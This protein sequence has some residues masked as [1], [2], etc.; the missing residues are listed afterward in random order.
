MPPRVTPTAPPID[1]TPPPAAVEPPLVA[2]APP[3]TQPPVTQ[4]TVE[5]PPAP[6]I[7]TPPPA[8]EIAAPPPARKR[9]LP[10]WLA[11]GAI[12]A[13]LAGAGVYYR[14]HRARMLNRL[15]TRLVSD[16]IAG[17]TITIDMADDANHSLRFVVRTPANLN[18]PATR[19]EF[20]PKGATA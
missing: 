9:G 3:V 7:A 13:M 20:I 14:N 6:T 12:A 5:Q 15:T 18:A 16:G 8:T 2:E 4:P 17:R 10:L 19:I 11:L 1:I